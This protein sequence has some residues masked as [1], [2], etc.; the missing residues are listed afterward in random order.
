MTA[1]NTTS[2]DLKPI[3]ERVAGYD[4]RSVLASSSM[5]TKVR[6]ETYLYRL[7]VD[8][9]LS[10]DS[11][12]WPSV[13]DPSAL[14]AKARFGYQDT[15][16]SLAALRAASQQY[17]ERRG[18]ASALTIAITLLLGEYGQNDRVDWEH[19]IPPATPDERSES[20]TFLGFDVCDQW[21]LSALMNYGFNPKDD[22]SLLRAVWG[23][24]LNRFH[25]F[26]DLQ[27]A[28]AF[29]QLSDRRLDKD[30]TPCFVFGLWVVK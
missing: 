14:E 23:A 10:A 19:V 9:P 4:T 2:P 3:I 5:W 27:H 16:A 24:R 11:T 22:V 6:K 20:W 28:I 18:L 21:L 13:V 25:L 17:F 15:W 29:K 1:M 7:D 30:H 8:Q 26:D 12:V